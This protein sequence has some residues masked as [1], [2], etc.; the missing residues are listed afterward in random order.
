MGRAMHRWTRGVC[1]VLLLSSFLACK[2]KSDEPAPA[3]SV[4]PAAE[5]AAAAAASAAAA[6]AAAA[7]SVAAA[8]AAA[9]SAG[10]LAV[11]DAGPSAP[12][13]GEVKRF[14]DKE[15]AAT[16]ST[17]ISIDASKIYDE[18]DA[19]KPSVTSLSKDLVVTRLATLG[20]EWTLV[21]FPSGVGKVSP[22]WIES[23]SLVGGGGVTSTV[24]SAKPATSATPAATASAKPAT[25]AVASAAPAATAAAT[26]SVAVKPKI[27]PGAILRAPAH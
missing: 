22:G 26:A 15:K 12:V 24:A 25:K 19:T 11:V 7:A 9:A 6:Q 18:P 10:A 27:K 20:S 16:G 1:G 3:A 8:Q 17:K 21:E 14:A 2:K 23:K 13:L 5:L 4:S